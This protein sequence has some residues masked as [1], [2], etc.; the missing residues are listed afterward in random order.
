M[1]LWCARPCIVRQFR[2]GHGAG[3]EPVQP[4]YESEQTLP[5]YGG[6]VRAAALGFLQSAEPPGVLSPG[7]QHLDCE[8]VRSDHRDEHR[9]AYDR[10]GTEALFLKQMDYPGRPGTECG[11]GP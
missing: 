5:Y 9:L 11:N 1:C 4:G 8:H 2:Q 3:S 7:A 6:E 10:A